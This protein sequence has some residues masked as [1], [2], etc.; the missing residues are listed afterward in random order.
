MAADG[1]VK[2]FVSFRLEV[3]WE[4]L[5][6]Y[7]VSRWLLCFSYWVRIELFVGCFIGLMAFE[8]RLFVCIIGF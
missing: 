8:G 2:L 7:S 3:I 5:V 4:F 6:F 1:D